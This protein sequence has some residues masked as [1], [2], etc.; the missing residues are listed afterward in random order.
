MLAV[1]VTDYPVGLLAD[2]LEKMGGI[3][4]GWHGLGRKWG[5]GTSSVEETEQRGKD[6]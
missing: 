4:E 5:A 2:R 1:V 3:G 6:I